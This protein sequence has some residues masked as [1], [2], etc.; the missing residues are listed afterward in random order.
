MNGIE[1]PEAKRKRAE[2]QIFTEVELQLCYESPRARPVDMEAVA[3]LASSIDA[4]GLLNPIT[5][6]PVQKSRA[7][8]ICAAFEIV[9]GLHRVKAFRRLGRATIPAF[10]Q[11]MDDLHAE[12]ALIDENLC[13]NDLSPAE[14]A[15]AQARRKAI[16]QQL[17]PETKLGGDRGNQYTG[18]KVALGQFGQ[19]PMPRF[20]E[21]ASDATGQSERSVRRDVTRGESLG[22]DAL[23]KVAR[24]SLDKGDE[25][26]ALAKLP[27][28]KRLELIKRAAAGDKVS[29]KTSVKQI[30]RNDREVELAARQVGLPEANCAIIVCDWPR[31][32]EVYSR[33]T[34]LDRSPDNHYPTEG[35]EW[36]ATELVRLIERAAAPDC[37]LVWCT[38]AASLIEDIEIAA[39][40]GF[41]A[42]RPRDGRGKLV[43]PHG[44]ALPPVGDGSY[45]SHQVW[46]KMLR[47]TGRWFIDRHEL[48]LVLVRGNIPAPAPGTQDESLFS[49]KRTDH[50][51][52]PERLLE[53]VERHWPNLRK[54]EMFRRGPARP[55]WL[56]W[57]N[58]A[59]EAA[60]P[61]PTTPTP[62]APVPAVVA[63]GEDNLEIPPCLR[64]GDAACFVQRDAPP[65]PFEG[66]A[67]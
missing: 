46:D 14:R 50:S 19:E 13:R 29:A 20:D 56:A 40:A 23:A 63:A 45:R 54:L 4:S 33:E 67:N 52:K 42:L 15:S 61:L 26:D 60:P 6:R 53:W 30:R 34:G 47:G 3:A 31:R 62:P 11:D 16:Y 41:C 44:V 8:Q 55:G 1:Q 10:V 66:R 18:P 64:R 22:E 27:A 58:Q 2:A 38:T 43:R 48:W 17:H 32:H 49:E 24:T 36:A 59:E 21:A 51:R 57:G 12:L 7:G 35:F 37:M 39:E 5:V 9:A 28:E 65:K 25:L